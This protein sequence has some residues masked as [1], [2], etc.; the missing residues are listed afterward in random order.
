[1]DELRSRWQPGPQHAK[2]HGT[3]Y[4]G[5]LCGHCATTLWEM[6][7]ASLHSPPDESL[8][9]IRMKT[10]STVRWEAPCEARG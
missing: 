8:H 1:M 2:P 9:T 4:G 3:L 10:I 6:A 7:F 5:I